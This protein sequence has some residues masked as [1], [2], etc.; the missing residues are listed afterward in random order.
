MTFRKY[1]TK[2]ENL[3]T[4]TAGI[5]GFCYLTVAQIFI[6]SKILVDVNRSYTTVTLFQFVQNNRALYYV[7]YEK[8]S[9]INSLVLSLG[10]SLNYGFPDKYS[11]ILLV[12]W[13]FNSTIHWIGTSYTAIRSI[14]IA[15]D[16]SDFVK[17]LVLLILTIIVKALLL[18]E[19]YMRLYE[20]YIKLKI[21]RRE[22]ESISLRRET[23]QLL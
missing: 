14:L 20:K 15:Y 8:N 1:F 6:Q 23:D 3:S 19:V 10:G 18:S 7:L 5:A 13:I 16:S 12:P 4:L 22:M 2:K 21:Y 11:W 9:Q 17:T